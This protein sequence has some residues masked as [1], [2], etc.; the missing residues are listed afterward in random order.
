MT[1]LAGAVSCASLWFESPG[2]CKM[3]VNNE[4]KVAPPQKELRATYIFFKPELTMYN[5]SQF[6]LVPVFLVHGKATKT[7]EKFN[8]DLMILVILG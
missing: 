3:V 2:P 5:L 1:P 8:I 7:E 6:H 4:T